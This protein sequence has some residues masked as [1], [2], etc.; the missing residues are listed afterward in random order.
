MKKVVVFMAVYNGE[1]FLSQQLDSLLSQKN[2]VLELYIRNDGSTDNTFEILSKYASEKKYIKFSTSKNQGPAKS[3]LDL[4]FSYEGNAN[5]YSFSDADDVWEPDKLVSA[6]QQLTNHSNIPTM[7]CSQ[8]KIVDENLNFIALTSPPYRKPSFKNALIET[9][10]SGGTIVL[11]KAAFKILRKYQ[12]KYVVMHDSWIY[13]LMSS[14]GRIIFSRDAKI[15]YR[16]H[17]YNDSSS[18]Q[19]ALEKWKRRLKVLFNK[20]HRFYNQAL[21]FD[22]LYGYK[23]KQSDKE[24]LKKYLNARKNFLRRIRFFLFPP[25]FKQR[26]LSTVLFL[27]QVFFKKI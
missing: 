6:T 25:V 17:E 26:K 9:V 12:P 11:N 24:T 7:Y 14:F 5:Y 2:I 22:R 27:L 15:L 16:Q 10:T 23:L 8:L 19:T 20:D 4:V 13:L 18:Y 3:F 21:E 1:K